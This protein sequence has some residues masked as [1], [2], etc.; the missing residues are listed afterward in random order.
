MQLL[1]FPR[2]AREKDP[3]QK[4]TKADRARMRDQIIRSEEK[5]QELGF[6]RCKDNRVRRCEGSACDIPLSPIKWWPDCEPALDF[7]THPSKGSL[8]TAYFSPRD[9]ETAKGDMVGTTC[10]GYEDLYLGKKQYKAK[11]LNP[12]SVSREDLAKYRREIS[13]AQE[14]SGTEFIGIVEDAA[15]PFEQRAGAVEYDLT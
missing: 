13:V 6:V 7:H 11:C 14:Y 8:V 10:I 3:Y 12:A 5:N 2:E 4:L 15:E 9:V 1:A